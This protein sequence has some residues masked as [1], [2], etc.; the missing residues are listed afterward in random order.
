MTYRQRVVA[1]AGAMLFGIGP[2]CP[3]SRINHHGN[4]FYMAYW[5][6]ATG[7]SVILLGLAVVCLLTAVSARKAAFV[8]ASTSCT[9]FATLAFTSEVREYA[10]FEGTDLVEGPYW[11]WLVFAAGG[12]LSLGVVVAARRRPNQAMQ[13]DAA[14]RR[15]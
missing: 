14:S 2:F 4:M 1:A 7:D 15:R 10:A 6:D 8:W 9:V 5:D 11:G 3:T 13:A 12:L